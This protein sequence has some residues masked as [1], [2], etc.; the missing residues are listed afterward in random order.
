MLW[1]AILQAADG[2]PETVVGEIREEVEARLQARVASTLSEV[3]QPPFVPPRSLPSAPRFPRAI[4]FLTLTIT[5]T[6]PSVVPL[7]RCSKLH[8]KREAP[9]VAL[10]RTSK[11]G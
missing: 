5:L 2:L 4:S 8:R 11:A 1:Q 9:S 3:I 10:G 7:A 6:L